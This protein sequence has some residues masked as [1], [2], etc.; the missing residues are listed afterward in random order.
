MNDYILQCNDES[1]FVQLIT[2][3]AL[4]LQAMTTVE[5]MCGRAGNPLPVSDNSV[6]S[7][8]A[9]LDTACVTGECLKGKWFEGMKEMT[10]N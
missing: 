10:S 9:P 6:G 1:D 4:D 2:G 5:S 7:D 3:N 8:L